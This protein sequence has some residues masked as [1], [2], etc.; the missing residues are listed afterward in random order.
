MNTKILKTIGFVSLL[1]MVWVSAIA[2]QKNPQAQSNAVQVAPAGP[3]PTVIQNPPSLAQP[4]QGGM[5]LPK[6]RDNGDYTRSTHTTWEVTDRDPNG[7]NCRMANNLSS[8]DQ[9][10]ANQGQ[11]TMNIKNWPVVGTIKQGQDFEINLGPAGFGIVYDNENQPWMY[12]ERTDEQGAASNCF[13]RANH[14]F[15][16]PIATQNVL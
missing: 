12:V 6:P 8:Y 15:V 5:N 1:G 14:R 11:V 4:G 9:L 3:V 2:C 10:L 16:Q 13:V 7:L